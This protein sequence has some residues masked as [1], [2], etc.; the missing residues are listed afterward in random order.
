MGQTM[1]TTT[2]AASLPVDTVRDVIIVGS[3]PA[4]FTA[5]I[6]AARANLRPLMYEGDIP[7]T[8]GGQLTTT[9]EVENFPGFPQGVSGPDLMEALRQQALR[10]GTEMVQ[11][12]VTR[13]DLSRRPF[14]VEADDEVRHA[15]SLIIATGATA[16][17]LGATDEDR[18]KNHGAS[19]CA[20]C[21]GAFFKGQEVVVVG[22]GDTAMEEAMFLTRF[23]T[24]VTVVHRRDSLRAS[25]TMQD[26]AKANPKVAFRWNA[27]VERYLLDGKGYVRGVTLRDTRTGEAT[28]LPC[29]G[30]F[31][32]VGHKPNTEVFKGILDLDE[33]GYV[34]TRGGSRGASA[35]SVPGV[36]A[37]GDVQDSYYRQA[38][39]AA[40]SGC[41]AAMDA[42]RF[43]EAEGH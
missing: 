1:H 25:K 37:C 19:A 33:Q 21:D 16:Q 43:L 15:R 36:F 17:W 2:D 35:T 5:A 22:G 28:D 6:Y 8:P 27:V 31:V 26:R 40:G 24:K 7:N 38:I 4:G 18:A 34:K 23:A 10:F 11:K 41:Q 13:V 9:T 32:A 42:E 39:T 30:V 3:G 12:N 14:R 29:Q 20:T